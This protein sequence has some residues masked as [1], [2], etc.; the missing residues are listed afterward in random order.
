V[1]F[2]GKYAIKVIPK[3]EIFYS[4]SIQIEKE[5]SLYDETLEAVCCHNDFY[6]H[7]LPVLYK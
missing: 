5:E 3:S 2:L 4:L 1:Y 6:G 7:G